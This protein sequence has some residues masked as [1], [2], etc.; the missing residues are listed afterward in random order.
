MILKIGRCLL[1]LTIFEAMAYVCLMS[2]L[3]LLGN[4]QLSRSHEKA[5]L[6]AQQER[7]LHAPSIRLDLD[8][9]QALENLRYRSV[10][11]KGRFDGKHQFLIDNQIR[12]GKPGFFVMTPFFPENSRQA[13]LVN[14]GWIALPAQ[15]S[16][17]P[18][19]ALTR[20]QTVIKGRINQ[21]PGV[22]WKLTGAE[23]PTDTWPALVQVIDHRV[24]SEK[25]GYPLAPFQI[26]LDQNSG[27]GYL[28]EWQ[29]SEAV[30]SPEKHVAYAMQWFG[31]AL[32]LTVLF[33]WHSC[34][35]HE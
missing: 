25:L 1:K 33:F 34:K 5:A 29:V 11:L 9:A 20:T 23:I 8:E 12:H 30:I 7:N 15:R 14:R 16:T 17:L 28:R 35:K 19:A 2:L 10:K 31:L 6:L 24:L 32:T 21:L 3:I 4:W 18:D 26:E 22:G 13:V 27:E